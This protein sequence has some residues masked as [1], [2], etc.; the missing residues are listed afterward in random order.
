MSRNEMFGMF[1]AGLQVA[2]YWWL[3]GI[4]AFVLLS[5]F[6]LIRERQVGIVV[7][8]FAGK[9]LAPGIFLHSRV[10]R[11]CKWTRS[12][13]ACTSAIGRGSSA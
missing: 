2:W 5:S 6:V 11:V 7:K 12:R 1:G 8:R 10:K 3:F 4:A 13:R 9:S